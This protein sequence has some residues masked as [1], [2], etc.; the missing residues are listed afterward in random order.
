MAAWKCAQC[1]LVN[2]ET[3]QACRRCG[4]APGA[5]GVA[6]SGAAAGVSNFATSPV[7]E[8][9]RVPAYGL[10]Q[11]RQPVQQMPSV[12]GGP[13]SVQ[14]ARFQ[15]AT[16]PSAGVWRDG[17]FLVMQKGA[18]LPNRCVK[19]NAPWNGQWVTRT[20]RAAESKMAFLRYIPY[21]RLIYWIWR[22]ASQSVEVS[23]GLCE[24]HH[25]QVNMMTTIGNLLRIAGVVLLVYGIYSDDLVWWIPGLLASVLGSGLSTT[26]IIKMS[27][28]D[29]YYVWLNG[30]D[31][32]YLA[33]L[34]PVH[35]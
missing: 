29:D 11:G 28:M 32:G 10:P 7:N 22:A 5:D 26:P 16:L 17:P 15:A 2:R 31:Q 12:W 21:L 14:T 33:S 3:D 25:S 24:R 23:F 6:T 19:C 1:M 27:Q 20:V 34:P 13:E 18:T 35:G 8:P 9:A 4:A 30:I